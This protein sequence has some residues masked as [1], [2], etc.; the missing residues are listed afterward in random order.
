MHMFNYDSSPKW[1]ESR[2]LI[3]KSIWPDSEVTGKVPIYARV[4]IRIIHI[5]ISIDVDNANIIEVD[6]T[7][8]E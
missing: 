6:T 8:T 3:K 7:C 5:F 1:S 2:R 4:L